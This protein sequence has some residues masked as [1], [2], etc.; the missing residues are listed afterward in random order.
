MKSKGYIKEVTEDNTQTVMAID[1]DK[2]GLS[3]L[4]NL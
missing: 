1:D 3:A 2:L 4:D